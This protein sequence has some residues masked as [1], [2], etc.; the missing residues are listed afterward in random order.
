M[1]IRIIFGLL[2]GIVLSL[3]APRAV[4]AQSWCENFQSTSGFYWVQCT[5]YA[6]PDNWDLGPYV[7]DPNFSGCYSYTGYCMAFDGNC[8]DD[9]VGNLP[10]Q[11]IPSYTCCA[12][13]PYTGQEYGGCYIQETPCAVDPGPGPGG[14]DTGGDDTTG[15]SCNDGIC[16]GAE[17]CSTC[18]LD[19]GACAINGTARARAVIVPSD[20]TNCADVTGST[21]YLAA[22]FGMSPPNT[23]VNTAAD[24]SYATWNVPIAGSGTVGYLTP[25]VSSQY[26]PKLACWTRDNP[27]GSGTGTAA[28]YS[29]DGSTI[30]WTIGYT[31]GAPWFQA[32]GGD[33][34]ASGTLRSYVSPGAAERVFVRDGTGGYPGMVMFDSSYDFDSSLVQGDG[35]VSSTNW[36]A[37]APHTT[38]DYYD[39]FY[40]RFGSPTTPYAFADLLAVTQ[41]ASSETPYYVVGDMTTSEDWVVGDG[42][43]VIFIVDGNVTIGGTITTVGTGFVAFIV[44]GDITVDTAV[45]TTYSLEDPVLQGIY[46]TSPTGTFAT[47]PTTMAL[48][49]RFVGKGMFIAGDFLLQRDLEGYGTGN[50]THAAELFIYDPQLLFTM[51]D[52]MK[53]LPVTWQEVAP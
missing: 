8:C 44:N 9:P 24:G 12:I 7:D 34:Y 26:V 51:P 13:D 43:S 29:V 11:C 53:E 3:S 45:G 50:T 46:I 30:T 41:P 47:G 38:V 10:P 31:L 39:Y 18:S 37:Y 21:S 23:V 1:Y 15:P 14:D 36:L 35:Y 52:P 4:Q 33:V 27:A 22:S 25:S 19:C 5:K 49:A 40:R 17:T 20:T 42:E 2:L 28:T 32:E 16:N 48:S 6:C